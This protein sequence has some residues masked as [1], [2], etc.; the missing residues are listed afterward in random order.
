MP[1]ITT[2]VTA[3]GVAPAPSS[4]LW[5]SIAPDPNLLLRAA[6]AASRRGP[7]RCRRRDRAPPAHPDVAGAAR[8]AYDEPLQIVRGE[9]AH[10]Y[11][12]GAAARYLDLVNNVAHVG[13]CH[14]RVVAAGAAADGAC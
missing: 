12:R 6:R 9:G 10:L 1:A 11:R 5:Q 2:P 14:P 7:G 13:H 4:A 3:P 8:L